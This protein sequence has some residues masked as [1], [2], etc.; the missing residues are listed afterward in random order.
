MTLKDNILA[1]KAAYNASVDTTIAA[2]NT[3]RSET[4]ASFDKTIDA[5]TKIATDFPASLI[6]APSGQ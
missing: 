1:Q 4:N 2:L 6:A 3:T 5:V